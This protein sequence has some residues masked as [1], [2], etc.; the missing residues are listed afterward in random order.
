VSLAG[1]GLRPTTLRRR[2]SRPQFKRDP[3]GINPAYLPSLWIR[4]NWQKS[5]APIVHRGR[6]DRAA[7]FIDSLATA[8]GVP[9]LE[10]LTYYLTSSVDDVYRIL[11]LETDK[12]WGPVGGLA[13]PVN[14]QLLSGIP[15]VGEDYRHE[16]AHM[17][18]MPLLMGRPTLYFISESVPTGTPR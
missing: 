17:V 9:R 13:Q 14:H 11:G 18:I 16:L 3:L 5:G 1:H 6:A 12:K 8:F 4:R 2:A 7:A 10:H 15:A